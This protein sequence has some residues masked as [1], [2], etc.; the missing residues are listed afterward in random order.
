L[1]L[2]DGGESVI[3]ERDYQYSGHWHIEDNRLIVKLFISVQY[4]LDITS[5]SSSSLKMRYIQSS[6]DAPK[7]IVDGE[8]YVRLNH[9]GGIQESSGEASVREAKAKVDAQANEAH[10]KEVQAQESQAKAHAQI[11]KLVIL[12]SSLTVLGFV[13]IKQKKNSDAAQSK[14]VADLSAKL[15][16]LKSEMNQETEAFDIWSKKQPE[17]WKNIKTR[18]IDSYLASEK[19]QLLNKWDLGNFLLEIRMDFVRK[20]Q[21]FLPPSARPSDEK[22]RAA[23][24]STVEPEAELAKQRQTKIRDI[25]LSRLVPD[26]ETQQYDMADLDEKFTE[27]DLERADATS[28]YIADEG[29]DENTFDEFVESSRRLYETMQKSSLDS[30]QVRTINS[31]VETTLGI[32]EA[33]AELLYQGSSQKIAAIQELRSSRPGLGLAEAKAIIEKAT[34]A[35]QKIRPEK[36]A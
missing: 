36:F 22:W 13:F 35:L 18:L 2:T 34:E 1:E 9:E 23:L 5:T 33:V 31:A 6:D 24:K 28:D 3:K 15:S 11:T 32:N 4:T 8:E 27:L 30:E 19:G 17:D 10:T 14:K 12:L 21:A 29:I 20:E 7:D 25:L 26:Y 16:V